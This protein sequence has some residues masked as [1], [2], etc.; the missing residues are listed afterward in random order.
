M[1]ALVS[2]SKASAVKTKVLLQRES[3]RPLSTKGRLIPWYP[4]H[5]R[6]QQTTLPFGLGDT[7]TLRES[8]SKTNSYGEGLGVNAIFKSSV[9]VNTVASAAEYWKDPTAFERC[10]REQGLLIEVNDADYAEPKL[11]VIS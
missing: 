5:P 4:K 9:R 1:R 6:G 10:C 8:T 2:A 7:V 3:P 11:A